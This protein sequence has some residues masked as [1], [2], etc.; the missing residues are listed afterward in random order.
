Q[1]SLR[2]LGFIARCDGNV[3]RVSQGGRHSR[4]AGL[5][6]EPRADRD[7]VAQTFLEDLIMP[8]TAGATLL[9]EV[10]AARRHLA[11]EQIE[12]L[13]RGIRLRR[14]R[15]SRGRATG[16]APRARRAGATAT[17]RSTSSASCASSCSCSTT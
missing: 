4:L 13:E 2:F 16:P 3:P 15:G 14:R 5:A 7:L 10:Y 8:K 9:D 1:K 11:T 17:G 6:R 12:P